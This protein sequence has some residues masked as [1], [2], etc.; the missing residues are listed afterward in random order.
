MHYKNLSNNKN[1]I[2][3]KDAQLFVAS[4]LAQSGKQDKRL[5]AVLVCKC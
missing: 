4:Q 2:Q 5:L 3:Q 1:I